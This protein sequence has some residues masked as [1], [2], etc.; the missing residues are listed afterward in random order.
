MSR[1]TRGE[2]HIGS[3]QILKCSV[4]IHNVDIPINLK[5][6]WISRASVLNESTII[7]TGQNHSNYH[8]ALVFDSYKHDDTGTYECTAS[9]L[10]TANTSALVETGNTSSSLSLVALNGVFVF[11]T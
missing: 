7:F 10:P 11:S 3:T 2:V 1:E 8:L 6:Q 5:M 9:I 4:A